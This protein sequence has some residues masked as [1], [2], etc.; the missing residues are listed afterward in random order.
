M[1]HRFGPTQPEHRGAALRVLDRFLVSFAH[2][3]RCVKDSVGAAP[4]CAAA[5]GCGLS[6]EE[7]GCEATET[8][9]GEDAVELIRRATAVLGPS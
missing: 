5:V 8:L 3:S 6:D 7:E 9:S 1:L 4:S 2:E